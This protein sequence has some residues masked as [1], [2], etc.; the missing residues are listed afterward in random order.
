MTFT[1]MDQSSKADWDQIFVAQ[2]EDWQNVAD[3]VLGLLRS[4][5]GIT[6]GFAVDQLEHALQTATRAERAGADDEVVVAALCHDIGKAI[7]EPNHPE[8]AAA[9]LR[10]YV[11]EDVVWMIRVHQDFQGRHFYEH[12]SRDPDARERHRGHPAYDL[13]RQFADEWDQAAFDPAYDTRPL[14]HFEPRVRRVFA[15]PR[16]L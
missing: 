1:R 12:L 10:P 4:L 9:L 14:D 2:I 8:I 11:R 16:H 13:A 5:A 6:A 15:E 3:R 7:C